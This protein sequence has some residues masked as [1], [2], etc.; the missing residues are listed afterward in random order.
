MDIYFREKKPMILTRE[1]L[2]TLVQ[3]KF[4]LQMSK[5]QMNEAFVACKTIEAAE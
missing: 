4:G 1:N 3:K 5:V 2:E